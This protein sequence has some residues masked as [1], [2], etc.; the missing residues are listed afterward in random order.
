MRFSFAWA[1]TRADLMHFFAGVFSG[2]KGVQFFSTL[3]LYHFL[4]SNEHKKN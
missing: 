3:A 4:P 1:E 2:G